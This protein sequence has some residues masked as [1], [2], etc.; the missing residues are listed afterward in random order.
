MRI[1]NNVMSYVAYNATMKSTRSLAKAS[2]KLATGLRVNSAADDAAGLAISEKMTA[3][4]RGL[5][6]ACRNAQDGMSLLQT[7]EGALNEIHSILQRMRELSIQAASDV[8]TAEDR[9]YIQLE[10]NELSRQITDIANQTQFNKKQLLNGDSAVLWSTSTSDI[11]VLVGGTLLKKD[12]FGQTVN[13][14]GNYKITFETVQAGNEQVQKSNILYLK[15]GT[16]DTNGTT[17]D[18]SGVNSFSAL[19]MVEGVWR[20]ET[21]AEPFG[22]VYYYQGNYIS[23]SAVGATLDKNGVSDLAPGEYAIQLSDNVPMMVDMTD[24]LRKGTVTDVNISSRGLSSNFDAVFSVNADITA[25]V[26][27]S[28]VYRN[29]IAILNNNYATGT[30]IADGVTASSFDPTGAYYVGMDTN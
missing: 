15:H 1:N 8:L 24:A 11:R 21:R 12:I 5:D 2:E 19:N 27:A 14:E 25:G 22:G 23:S 6:Q 20:V 17:D 18:S 9:S 30:I 13:A 10:V 26:S 16:L 4:I 29:D 7:A 3:Q 28:I